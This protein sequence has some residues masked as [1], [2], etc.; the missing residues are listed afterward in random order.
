MDIEKR[1]AFENAMY[2]V[3]STGVSR[4]DE[5]LEEEDVGK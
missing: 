1:K 4:I 2:K 3:N 5:I